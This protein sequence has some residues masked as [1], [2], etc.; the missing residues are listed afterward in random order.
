MIET[1]EKMLFTK[2]AVDLL[3]HRTCDCYAERELC[4]TYLVVGISKSSIYE[5]KVYSK[6]G[7]NQSGIFTFRSKYFKF[8]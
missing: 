1:V 5:V 4:S 7:K 2:R 3:F 6:C 8:T